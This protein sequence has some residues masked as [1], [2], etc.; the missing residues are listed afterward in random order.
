MIKLLPLLLLTA[1]TPAVVATTAV[2]LPVGYGADI[3]VNC[4]RGGTCGNTISGDTG[5]AYN[6][7]SQGAKV[8]CGGYELAGLG[9]WDLG[10]FDQC[11]WQVFNEKL[12]TD[13]ET[14]N[15][16]TRTAL[17]EA[18]RNAGTWEGLKKEVC[19]DNTK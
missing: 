6:E 2:M 8:L 13:I 19:D 4:A 3:A 1:C 5:V 16:C 15:H 11:S 10:F 18:N 9:L 7:G 17:F 12:G 14:N